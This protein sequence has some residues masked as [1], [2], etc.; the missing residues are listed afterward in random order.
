MNDFKPFFLGSR[1]PQ[2]NLGPI[3]VELFLL[4]VRK[5]YHYPEIRILE[6][7]LS[8]QFRLLLLAI[9]LV[10][11]IRFY[12]RSLLGLVLYYHS[13]NTQILIAFTNLY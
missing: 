3:F 12:S 7:T 11:T 6:F 10:E 4:I 1:F 13:L 5:S 8:V 2:V 9:F